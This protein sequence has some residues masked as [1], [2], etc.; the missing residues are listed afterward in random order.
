MSSRPIRDLTC[1]LLVMGHR[2][3]VHDPAIARRSGKVR[4]KEVEDRGEWR[5]SGRGGIRGARVVRSRAWGY[6][7][8]WGGAGWSSK[9]RASPSS[10]ASR[11]ALVTGAARGIG[12]GSR[13]VSRQ[14]GLTSVAV[15]D[16]EANS[17]DLD[18]VAEGR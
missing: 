15:N 11:G 10:Y 12:R 8:S 17:D 4:D 7:G 2:S 9:G 3:I 5:G 14:T 1:L 6:R 13:F 16:V 18:S